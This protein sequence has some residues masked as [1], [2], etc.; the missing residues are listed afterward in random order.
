MCPEHTIREQILEVKLE[1]G[2]HRMETRQWKA[3]LEIFEPPIGK[4]SADSDTY[5]RSAYCHQ[6]LNQLRRAVELYRVGLESDPSAAWARINLADCLSHLGR[7]QEAAQQWQEIVRGSRTPEAFLQLVLSYSHLQRFPEL[8]KALR[9]AREL[10]KGS[11]E[12]LYHLGLAKL[13]NHRLREV[14][15]LIHRAASAGF[16][17]ARELTRK[18]ARW[19]EIRGRT[20]TRAR[21]TTD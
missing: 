1:T 16:E 4:W 12:L 21:V 20:R 19:A 13:H 6:Q 15:D 7:Y 10:G 17:P 14:W 5:L 9:Q 3:A 2:I 8:E 11:P 18:A